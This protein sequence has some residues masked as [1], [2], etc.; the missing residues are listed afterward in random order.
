MRIEQAALAEL[1]QRCLREAVREQ[2]DQVPQAA[3]PLGEIGRGGQPTDSQSREDGL[4]ERRH[5]D[6]QTP[7]VE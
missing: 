6:H 4:G 3:E 5:V 2:V 1:V 7:M